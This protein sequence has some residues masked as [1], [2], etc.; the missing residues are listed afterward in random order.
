[1][2]NLLF[3]TIFSLLLN[4]LSAQRHYTLSG[5]IEE[6]GSGERL[7]QATIY[8][9]QTGKGTVCNQYGFYSLTLPEGEYSLRVDY[10]GYSP[11][12]ATIHLHRDTSLTFSL[13]P[14]SML[15]EVT[16]TGYYPFVRSTLTGKHSLRI[17]QAKAM[18]SL[19][20][21]TDILKTLQNLPGVNSGTEG[22]S[23]FSVRGGSPEQTQILLDGTP[24]YNVNHAMGYFS[25]F[26][27]EALQDLTLYKS[28]IPARY[29]GRLSS[30]LDVTMK[31]GNM[32]KYTGDIS[33]SPL[34]GSL[35]LQGPIKKD[36]ASFLIS[37]RRTWLDAL[38]GLATL[39]ASPESR[40]GYGFYD[41]NA[42]VNWKVGEQDRLYISFYNG[43]DKFYNHWKTDGKKD[44][45]HYY[46]GNI[47]TSIRWNHVLTPRMFFNVQ[48]Y[49]SRF[50]FMTSNRNYNNEKKQYEESRSRS[51][52]EEVTTK[53]DFDYLPADNHHLRYGIAVSHKY[54]APETSFRT[55]L[56]NDSIWKDETQGGLWSA[57]FY[58]EDDWQIASKWRANIGIR[59]TA[60]YP[61]K[62]KYYSLEPRLA[63][64]FLFNPQNSLKLSWSSM[65]QP[66]HLLTNSALTIQT[67]LWVPV[68]DKVKPAWS[69]LFSLGFYSQFSKQLEFSTELYY[70]DLQRVIRY[71]EGIQYLKQKDKSWQDYIYT[72]KGRAY[73]WE[74]MLNKNKGALQ[75]W[76]S[77]SL[78]RAERS[79]QG[80]Q[81]GSW[82]PFEYDRRHKLNIV[83]DYT[84]TDRKHWKFSKTFAL[85]FVYTSGNYITCGR[86][87]YP[88]APMPGGSTAQ[89]GWGSWWEQRE[90]IDRPNNCR[91]PAYHHLDIAY[92]L[93]NK[94]QKGSSWSFGIYNLYL[95]KNPSFYYRHSRNGNEEIRRISILPFA[96][97]VTWKY[98]F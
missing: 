64:T 43:R 8:A 22:M 25:V 7:G 11:A 66:L 93:K 17:E 89:Q 42:K 15:E 77:Y 36:K 78:S 38:L 33:L 35:T 21:E 56:G 6:A 62:Q 63:L 2:K 55:T 49:Y 9:I 48:A 75:G 98:H 32:K 81:Q 90:Y 68:T 16:V 39:A 28:G 54:F 31:E 84:F 79:Y 70:N 53:A 58:A 96:P 1:M 65:Q 95:R 52:L 76:I 69:Q 26:N 30:V 91:L 45:Y 3:L 27:G 4:T 44:K 94:K 85:N 23:S 34:A 10:V 60:L 59:A 80:I 5:F 29:G 86:Q 87:T 37:A 12:F 40:L 73:G 67:D 20:G 46:W 82:F 97:S 83:A 50:Q 24:V 71:Q 13:S 57:E 41:L 18:P 51:F 92:H 14:A 72:G 74:V 19:L 88:A 61:G 47:S